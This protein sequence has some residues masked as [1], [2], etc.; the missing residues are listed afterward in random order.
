MLHFMPPWTQAVF[1]AWR[2]E[3]RFFERRH[4]VLR[5]FDDQ[6]VLRAFQWKSDSLSARLGDHELLEIRSN[7]AVVTLG[8]PRV[9]PEICRNALGTALRMLKPEHVHLHQILVQSVVPIER[10]AGEAAA[11]SLRQLLP[12][13]SPVA[14]GQDWAFMFDGSSTE[15]DATFQVEFGAISADEVVDRVTR[16]TG[17]VSPWP[18]FDIVVDKERL[19]EAA[20][21]F[22]W[23]WPTSYA[24]PDEDDVTEALCHR[25]SVITE[26]SESLG[27]ALM[28]ELQLQPRT[29]DAEDKEEVQ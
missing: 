24:L 5:A 19:P 29:L 26:E 22:A 21:F 9:S 17:R 16:R 13:L 25:W 28:K 6:G 8:S 4:D 14:R 15:L 2:P 18:A 12:S 27:L 7:G 1:I 11:V 23:T 20:V 3:L 10:T